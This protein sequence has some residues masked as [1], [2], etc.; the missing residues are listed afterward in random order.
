M[1]YNLK[2]T[3]Y[4][5]GEQSRTKYEGTMELDSTVDKV[6]VGKKVEEKIKEGMCIFGVPEFMYKYVEGTVDLLAGAICGGLVTT[7]FQ[8]L[9]SIASNDSG[10]FQALDF[11]ISSTG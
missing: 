3:W 1:I 6:R 5:E 10:I 8:H 11:Y 4:R 9:C 7:E 2:I